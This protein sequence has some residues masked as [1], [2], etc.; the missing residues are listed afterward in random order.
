MSYIIQK[1]SIHLFIILCP[2][3]DRKFRRRVV[4]GIEL[5]RIEPISKD[6]AVAKHEH[7]VVSHRNLPESKIGEHRAPHEAFKPKTIFDEL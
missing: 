4:F 7:A 1:Q 6:D 3:F 2:K 5:H